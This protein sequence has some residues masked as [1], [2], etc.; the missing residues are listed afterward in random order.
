MCGN[1]RQIEVRMILQILQYDISDVDPQNILQP[2][3]DGG[4]FARI[5][6][7]L[8]IFSVLTTLSARVYIDDTITAG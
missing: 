2:P 4:Y 8:I 6:F 7:L 1:E 5:L 3:T